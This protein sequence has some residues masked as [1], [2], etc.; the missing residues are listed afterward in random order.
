MLIDC[1]LEKDDENINNTPSFP[2]LG[3]HPQ[4]GL[5]VY[6][7]TKRFTNRCGGLCRGA[8]RKI[9]V[10]GGACTVADQP[11]VH[12]HQ[13]IGRCGAN[14]H[15]GIDVDEATKDGRDEMIASILTMMLYLR[16]WKN[17]ER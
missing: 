8:V 13:R 17:Y 2:H 6:C 14:R 4:V 7:P 1:E 15:L 5:P 12:G 16:V 10:G 3:H 11:F 9:A